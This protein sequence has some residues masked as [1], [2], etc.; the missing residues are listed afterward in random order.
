MKYRVYW[1]Q[2]EDGGIRGHLPGPARL[3][4]PWPAA[5]RSDRKHPGSHRGLPQKP[6]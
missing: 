6:V 3:C 4:L 5:R 2:D 1:E